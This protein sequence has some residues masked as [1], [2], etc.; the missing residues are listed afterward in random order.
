MFTLSPDQKGIETLEPR[1][2]GQAWEFTLSPDQKGIETLVD[3][4]DA[5]GRGSH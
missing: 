3:G 4:P 2:D 1:G 5:I